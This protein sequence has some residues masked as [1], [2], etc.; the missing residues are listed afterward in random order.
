MVRKNK[1]Q[2]AEGGAV[3][4]SKQKVTNA[5]GGALLI[6]M[7]SANTYSTHGAGE[8]FKE[9]KTSVK[10]LS[11]SVITLIQDNALLQWRV[12]QLESD[13]DGRL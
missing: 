12:A 3:A 8:E 2:P 1:K 4:T 7:S 9:L 13:N 5:L 6:V 10:E 11:G